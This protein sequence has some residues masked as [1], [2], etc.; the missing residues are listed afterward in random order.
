M[1]DAAQRK[2]DELTAEVARNEAKMR[3]SQQRELRLL[4]A[5]DLASLFREMID[6]LRSSYRLRT[7]SVVLCDPDHDVRHLML[8][9][10]TPAEGFDNLLIRESL[11]GLAPQYVAL[12]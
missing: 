7:V 8:A 4:Q 10:G 5:E 3:R 1:P 12:R 2:L 11:S 6:G 9:A